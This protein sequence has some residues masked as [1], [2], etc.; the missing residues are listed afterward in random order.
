MGD[1]NMCKGCKEYKSFD[2]LP[3]EL[4]EKFESGARDKTLQQT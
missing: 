1:D 2:E 3:K 4:K